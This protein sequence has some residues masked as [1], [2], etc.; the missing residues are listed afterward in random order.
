[1]I[2]RNQ[3][4]LLGGL[5]L[6]WVVYYNFRY[7]HRWQVQRLVK[8][9]RLVVE[10]SDEIHGTRVGGGVKVVGDVALIHN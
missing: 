6:T 8:V 9:N 10:S 4:G 3:R 2:E 1:M 5:L 7:R